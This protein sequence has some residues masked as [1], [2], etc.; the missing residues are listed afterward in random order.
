MRSQ[1]MESAESSCE[2]VRL[3]CK[4]RG[5]HLAAHLSPSIEDALRRIT[6]GPSSVDD[7]SLRFDIGGQTV[8]NDREL[9][10]SGR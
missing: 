8:A 2:G 10:C 3:N 9:G 5:G 7:F 6:A 4:I 1:Q